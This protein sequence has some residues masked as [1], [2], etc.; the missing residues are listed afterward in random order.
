M[1]DRS[2]QASRTDQSGLHSHI[3]RIPPDKSAG[4]CAGSCPYKRA[5]RKS[6][7][8]RK[9]FTFSLAALHHLKEIKHNLTENAEINHNLAKNSERAFVSAL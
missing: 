5:N 8:A 2:E 1:A 3:G 7:C 6:R 9:V 4:A